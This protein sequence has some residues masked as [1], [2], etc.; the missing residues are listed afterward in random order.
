[1]LSDESDTFDLVERIQRAFEG[2]NIV[3]DALDS[4]NKIV[5][6]FKGDAL[7]LPEEVL[8]TRVDI[9]D[10][11][12]PIVMRPIVENVMRRRGFNWNGA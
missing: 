5:F 8:A 11:L 10:S 3:V 9:M 12:H 6:A 1:L 2:A 7:N 4:L